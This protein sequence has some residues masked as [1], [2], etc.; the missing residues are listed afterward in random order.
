MDNPKS[1]LLDRVRQANNILVTV[2]KNPSVDQL[3]AAIGLTLL[4]NKMGKHATAVFSGSVPSTIDFLKPEETIEKNTDSL[5][6]FIIA[7]DK[8]KADKLRYKVEDSHVKIFITPYRT[9]ISEADLNFSQGD[10]NVEVVVALGVIEQVDLDQAITAHGRI[11]H[12]ATTATVTTGQQSNLGSINWSDGQA[13]SLCE[14]IASVADQLQSGVLDSQM[15]TALMTG[16]VAETDRFSNGKTTPATMSVSA[17]LM[18][19]GANQQLVASELQAKEKQ[20]APVAVPVA[21]QPA[22]AVASDDGSLRIEH[23]E[24]ED[25]RAP[26]GEQ[27]SIVDQLHIDEDGTASLTNELAPEPEADDTPRSSIKGGSSLILEPPTLGGKLT[28]NSEPEHLDPSVDPMTVHADEQPLLSHQPAPEQ[29]EPLEPLS[30]D[31]AGVD[32]PDLPGPSLGLPS[33]EAQLP[34]LDLPTPE[35]IVSEPE[36]APVVEVTPDAPLEP[37]DFSLADLEASVSS[38]HVTVPEP[39]STE[40]PELTGVSDQEVALPSVDPASETLGLPQLDSFDQAPLPVGG[41]DSANLDSARDA[42]SAAIA[43]SNQPLPPIN[44][45]GAQPLDLDIQQTGATGKLDHIDE[46]TGI[47][48]FTMPENLVPPADDLPADPTASQVND[49]TQAPDLPPPLTPDIYGAFT[50]QGPQQNGDNGQPQDPGNPF[51]LP[52]A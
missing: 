18:A 6:D 5:R 3:S 23:K 19:S 52:P 32:A 31:I 1:Q 38:P 26:D 24:E 35:P 40:L 29:P 10:F 25:A 44:A 46:E 22:A 27:N 50:G 2:S 20:P 51:N 45:L 12:D 39:A 28:A 14:M 36:P 49:P 9:S 33:E 48:S 15:A 17:A 21:T 8:S 37:V 34:P 41:D 7:L 13:S 16:V 30:V 47:P 11:L 42:V 43:A 4:L